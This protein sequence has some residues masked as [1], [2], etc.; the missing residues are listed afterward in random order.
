MFT[1]VVQGPY[2]CLPWQS[3]ANFYDKSASWIWNIPN[4]WDDA[5]FSIV[6]PFARNYNNNFSLPVNAVLHIIVDNTCEVFNNGVKLFSVDDFSYNSGYP[7]VKVVLAPGS[8]SFVFFAKNVNNTA[9]PGKKNPAGL[10][11]S[12]IG[13]DGYCLFHS[14]DDNCP[15]HTSRECW[16]CGGVE[17]H[18]MRSTWRSDSFTIFAAPVNGR[19][20][21]N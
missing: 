6:V 20:G 21:H 9:L 13:E 16:V 14:G 3:G 2:G 11:Y 19:C 7:K 4:A 18:A 8:N 15:I 1:E 10:I 17:V 12:V 5:P